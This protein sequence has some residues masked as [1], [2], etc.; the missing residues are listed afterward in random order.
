MN[1]SRVVLFVAAL[2]VCLVMTLTAF[3]TAGGIAP[4]GCW[5]VDTYC[6]G[7]ACTTPAGTPGSK[8]S[9]VY[10]CD[11]YPYVRVNE[12]CCGS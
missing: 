10:Y 12:V 5:W 3:V 7:P 9:E 2:V 8:G 6:G 11:T 1:R 4:S